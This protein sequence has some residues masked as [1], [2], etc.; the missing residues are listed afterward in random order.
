MQEE[1]QALPADR[2]LAG[3]DA[4][5]DGGLAEPLDGYEASVVFHGHAHTGS[6]V[7]KT[8]GCVPVYN[9]SLPILRTIGLVTPYF[10]Y[11]VPLLQGAKSAI[12]ARG[13]KGTATLGG[14]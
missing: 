5:G 2:G 13:A 9:V 14:P 3:V 8:A 4:F 10:V 12:G 6:F 11:E 7:V 1:R